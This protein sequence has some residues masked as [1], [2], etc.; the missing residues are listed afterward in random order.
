M[1]RDCPSLAVLDIA[2]PSA[3]SADRR[4]WPAPQPWPECWRGLRPPLPRQLPERRQDCP[5]RRRRPWRRGGARRVFERLPVPPE[6]RPARPAAAMPRRRSPAPRRRSR[7]GGRGRRRSRTGIGSD[8]QRQHLRFV[9]EGQSDAIRLHLGHQH[10]VDLFAGQHA[11][12]LVAGDLAE[13]GSALAFDHQRAG[14]RELAPL[15]SP[16][17]ASPPRPGPDGESG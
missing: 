6:P 7:S 2:D 3:P 11:A 13:I 17:T 4:R 5:S 16:G 15:Q 10:A 1:C 9:A 8:L 14:E 12:R